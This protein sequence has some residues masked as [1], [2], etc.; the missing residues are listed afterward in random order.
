MNMQ[1]LRSRVG[2]P[3]RAWASA[4]LGVCL[5]ML[6][7][8][9]RADWYQYTFN[10][11]AFNIQSFS[12]RSPGQNEFN[13]PGQLHIEFYTWT[14]LTGP[15]TADDIIGFKMSVWGGGPANLASLTWPLE[16][17]GCQIPAGCYETA[18]RFSIGSLDANGL[19][20]I[21]DL[22]LRQDF[23]TTGF[24][25]SFAIESS[26]AG[27]SLYRDAPTYYSNSGSYSTAAGELGGV[28]T[29]ALVP[30]PESYAL[31]LAGLLVVGGVARRARGRV[32][33]MS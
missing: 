21:W 6:G 15:A 19:P 12:V 8:P 30:E 14:P 23:R 20:T 18:S 26:Q 3:W 11:T 33:Q 24:S 9:A 29:L 16:P 4:A 22:Y 13:V 10:S 31:M 7:G 28:W 17:T 25:E 5:L 1:H 2:F 27:G 32:G